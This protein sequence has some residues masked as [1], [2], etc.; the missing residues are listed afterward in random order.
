LQDK[1]TDVYATVAPAI[2]GQFGDKVSM[3]S[4]RTALKILGFKDMIE[5]AMFADLII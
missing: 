1:D 3:G 5:V 4:L 2:V